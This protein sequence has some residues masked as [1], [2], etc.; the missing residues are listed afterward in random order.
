M[1]VSSNTVNRSRPAYVH[2]DGPYSAGISSYS[3]DE[4][5]EW[6]VAIMDADDDEIKVYACATFAKAHS[7][8]ERIARDRHIEFVN[9][10]SPWS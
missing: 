10:A 7:L 3:G 6:T 2:V 9:D 1:A 4:Y 8:G 5:P